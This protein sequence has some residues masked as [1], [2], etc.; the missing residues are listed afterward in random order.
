VFVPCSIE[1]CTEKVMRGGMAQH[2]DS[3]CEYVLVECDECDSFVMRG[4]LVS[5]CFVT[6][7]CVIVV[8]FPFD[9]EW[10]CEAFV[11]RG[12]LVSGRIRI[13]LNMFARFLSTS[14]YC[15]FLLLVVKWPM[16][17]LFALLYDRISPRHNPSL[18]II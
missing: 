1:N 15:A 16:G 12:Q 3:E 13:V 8:C 7:S 17:P 10:E 5:D 11:M 6:R 9:V 4:Q 14:Q 18:S 2:I